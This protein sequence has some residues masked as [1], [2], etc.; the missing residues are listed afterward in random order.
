MVTR[1]QITL[2]P[3]I[4]KRA[5]E[6]AAR[7]GISLAEYIRRLVDCDLG[8]QPPA[9]DPSVVFNLGDSGGSDV[10]LHK[11]AMVREAVAEEQERPDEKKS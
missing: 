2:D 3:E 5:R 11:D 8:D 9:A 10:A 6:K 7:A 1:T 4:L